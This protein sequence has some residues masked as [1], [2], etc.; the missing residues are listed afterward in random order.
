MS[1][2][3]EFFIPYVV[4]YY[5]WSRCTYRE[6]KPF[7]L[8]T[9]LAASRVVGFK[10]YRRPAL[11]AHESCKVTPRH[12]R[13][14]SSRE[15][16]WNGPVSSRRRGI[17]SFSSA[18]S[19]PFSPPPL[20]L[21][22]YLSLSDVFAFSQDSCLSGWLIILR[23]ERVLYGIVSCEGLPEDTRSANGKR[24]VNSGAYNPEEHVYS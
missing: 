20:L 12:A 24:R 10:A 19:A 2:P 8:I 22:L 17:S 18:L 5:T 21:S 9:P 14:F 13:P 1:T 4:P 7:W 23:Y 3:S 16:R 6:S 15:S 11:A